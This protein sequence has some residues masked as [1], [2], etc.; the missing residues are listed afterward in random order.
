MECLSYYK[1]FILINFF[2]YF[3]KI[4]LYV[5]NTKCF[6][7][8][9]DNSTKSEFVGKEIL[10]CIGLYKDGIHAFIVVLFVR[11]HFSVE[12]EIDL[13]DFKTFFGSKIVDCL[14]LVCT[15]LPM[16]MLWKMKVA[17]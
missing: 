5:L 11:T 17:S 13:R 10:K 7:G 4:L 15:K 12:E 9:F 3:L 6:A 2:S 8:L 14:I 16:V 1:I